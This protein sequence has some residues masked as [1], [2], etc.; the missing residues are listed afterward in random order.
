TQP[1]SAVRRRSEL[2]QFE[3]PPQ[4]FLRQVQLVDPCEQALISLLALGPADDF[5]N[6]GEEHIH[7]SYRFSIVVLTHVERFNRSGI[8]VEDYLFLKM[9]FHQVSLVFRLE[10][11]APLINEELEFFLFVR[12][13]ILKYVDS[14]RIAQ[15]LEVVF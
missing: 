9:F 1:E 3:V 8:V 5:T 14:L 12:S 4:V 2:A 10:V 7:R 11:N 15:A 6:S 13:R